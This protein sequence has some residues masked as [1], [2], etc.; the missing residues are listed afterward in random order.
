MS[1]MLVQGFRKILNILKI[2]KTHDIS[3]KSHIFKNSG[4]SQ[5]NCEIYN[6]EINIYCILTIYSIFKNPYVCSHF[7][8]RVILGVSL[9]FPN[10]RKRIHSTVYCMRGL[11]ADGEGL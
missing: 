1:V 5:Y 8:F 2:S 4:K 7:L 10:A 11:Y 9:V 6:C 3:G